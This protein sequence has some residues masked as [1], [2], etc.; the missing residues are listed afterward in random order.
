[1]KVKLNSGNDSILCPPS[2]QRT[3]AK[4]KEFLDSKPPKGDEIEVFTTS[5]LCLELNLSYNTLTKKV[6]RPKEM[7]AY[8][9]I[10]SRSAVWGHPK[11]VK[12]YT[13]HNHL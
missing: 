5:G 9:V 2:Y 12:L 10:Q 1:M 3:W 6:H 7:E 4:V 11:S 8:Y 13:E